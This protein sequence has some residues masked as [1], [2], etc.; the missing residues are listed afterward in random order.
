MAS[1]DVVGHVIE[2]M[3]PNASAAARTRRLGGSTP[4]ESTLCYAFDGTAAE[5]LDLK[6]ML[7]G[8]DGGGLTMVLPWA[9]ATVTTGAARWEA[10]IRRIQDDAED[11]DASHTYDFNG[12]T[13]TTAS[14]AGELSYPTIT[15]TDGA[16]MDSWAEGELAIVRIR[17]LPTDAGDTITED[18]QLFGWLIRET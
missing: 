17:R 11:L 12:V 4:A 14:A 9:A 8:Y 18:T 7:R 5:Y 3:P 16:D 6:V 13:D 1:G 2:V 15:F 10:A